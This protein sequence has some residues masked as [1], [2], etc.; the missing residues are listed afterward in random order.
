M[1]TVGVAPEEPSTV[2]RVTDLRAVLARLDAGDLASAGIDIPIGLPQSGPRRCDVEARQMVGP[3]RSS[4]FPA[5]VRGILGSTTYDD[6][7]RRCRALSGKGLSRQAFGIL[8]KVHEVDWLM[9]PERQRHLVE[10]HPEVSFTAVSGAPMAHYKKT[11][12]GRDERLAALRMSFA[13]VDGHA[14]SRIEGVGDDDVLDAFA[15][16]WSARRWLARTHV[17]LGGDTDD[18][19]LR[20]EIIA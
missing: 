10:V 8:A 6:A 9:T 4:V 7:A 2:E 18:R 12:A 20:M 15:A 17:Q 1:V 11:T 14:H 13:D 5:P 3:R 16:A 19:D